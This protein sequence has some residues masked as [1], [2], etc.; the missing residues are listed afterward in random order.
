MSVEPLLGYSIDWLAPEGEGPVV[1][2]RILVYSLSCGKCIQELSNVSKGLKVGPDRFMFTAL[3]SNDR[4]VSISLIAYGMAET[5]RERRREGLLELLRIFTDAPDYYLE[6][7]EEWKTVVAAN[8]PEGSPFDQSATAWAFAANS[9]DMQVR[10]LALTNKLGAP[11]S[12]ELSRPLVANPVARD[13]DRFNALIHAL[14]TPWAR[15]SLE[16]FESLSAIGSKIRFVNP[17]SPMNEEQWREFRNWA[18][19]GAYWLWGG[20]LSRDVLESIVSWEAAYLLLRDDAARMD[21][22]NQ[23]LDETIVRAASGPVSMIDAFGM[24]DIETLASPAWSAAQSDARQHL[25][26]ANYLGALVIRDSR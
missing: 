22:L 6:N 21:R 26:F 5:D 15:P 13:S 18:N 24:V 23:W 3:K 8:W 20:Q 17:L 10:I 11:N 14:A 25:V 16:G 7:P 19:D 9:I 4:A 12:I 1:P 2:E